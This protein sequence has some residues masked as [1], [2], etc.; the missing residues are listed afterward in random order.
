MKALGEAEA[1]LAQLNEKGMID[2][3]LTDGSDT[4]IFG[5]THV[6]RASLSTPSGKNDIDVTSY[7]MEQIE[8][9]HRVL[10]LR[11]DIILYALLAGGDCNLDGLRGCGAKL[12]HHLASYTGLGYQL[13]HAFETWPPQEFSAY[14]GGWRDRLR[15]IL[16]TEDKLLFSRRH[17]ALAKSIP[18][19]FPPLDVLEKYARPVI[20]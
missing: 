8:G 15:N 11:E 14:L 10:L 9:H 18:D 2:T 1:E 7:A 5:A 19:S 13:V 16:L 17:V 6:I 20:S 3:I 12:V 4:F